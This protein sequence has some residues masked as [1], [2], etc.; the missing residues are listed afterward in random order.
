MVRSR[1]KMAMRWLWSECS[2][3]GRCSAVA[4]QDVVVN[5][6]V[7]SG[8]VTLTLRSGDDIDL[9][10]DVITGGGSVY[11]TAT[12]DTVDAIRG[13]DMQ[14]GTFI[15]TSGGNVRVLADNEGDILLSQIDAGAGDVSLLAEGSILDNEFA[16]NVRAMRCGWWLMRL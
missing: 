6:D 9:N 2:Y 4:R 14:G 10:A 16:V 12:N 1:L 11:L 15:R 5:S 8:A 13:V 7:L 3:D